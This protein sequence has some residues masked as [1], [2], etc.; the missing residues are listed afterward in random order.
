MLE[1]EAMNQNILCCPECEFSTNN[2][3]F[4]QEHISSHYV[5]QID[6]FDMIF[7]G[8]TEREKVNDASLDDADNAKSIPIV[9]T[10]T[11]PAVANTTPPVTAPSANNISITPSDADDESMGKK[12]RMKV[13]DIWIFKC[14][15]CNIKFFRQRDMDKHMDQKHKNNYHIRGG[16]DIERTT[17]AAEKDVAEKIMEL[18]AAV[19]KDGEM[20]IVVDKQ[21]VFDS[22][23]SDA[24]ASD[25]AEEES[26][27][28]GSLDSSSSNSSSS[29]KSA[30]SMKYQCYECSFETNNEVEYYL[31]HKP[32]H[33]KIR[34]RHFDYNV[35]KKFKCDKCSFIGDNMNSLSGH[36]KVHSKLVRRIMRS[37]KCKICGQGSTSEHGMEIHMSRYHSKNKVQSIKSTKQIEQPK[38]V[39]KCDICDFTTTKQ[40]SHAGHMNNHRNERKSKRQIVS[41]QPK[42][43]HKYK[44][45]TCD[46]GTNDQKAYAR[47]C[48]MHKYSK[49]DI[50]EGIAKEPVHTLRERKTADKPR[51]KT[52]DLPRDKSPVRPSAAKTSQ[53]KITAPKYYD[54]AT[55]DICNLKYSHQG[56]YVQHLKTFKHLFMEY[57]NKWETL[58]CDTCFEYYDTMKEFN[59]HVRSEHRGQHAF[60]C[61]ECGMIDFFYEIDRAED[62]KSRHNLKHH[63]N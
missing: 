52:L 53:V 22:H 59:Q 54:K 18:P 55:C 7:M 45:S 62:Y 48:N 41:E 29:D 12:I 32:I 27:S 3:K 24:D 10:I 14:N 58:Y 16:V 35:E 63:P 51:D 31:G 57:L 38:K 17:V 34:K 28:C 40:Q 20:P 21:G 5:A 1:A 39:F 9:D 4:M 61:V 15:D 26:S 33:E 2:E 8:E 60:V 43:S 30:P 47:H 11:Q 37:H 23:V 6:M 25:V 13:P 19:S 42:T 49:K 44:C 50:A 36:K 56:N 46:F